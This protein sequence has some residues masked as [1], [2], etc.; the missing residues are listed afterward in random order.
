M[1]VGLVPWKSISRRTLEISQPCPY[2]CSIERRE[3]GGWDPFS[4]AGLFEEIS[5]LKIPRRTTLLFH[6]QTSECIWSFRECS[7][8]AV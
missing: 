1:E 3:E 8:F 6:H 2:C 7:S 5:L 4:E